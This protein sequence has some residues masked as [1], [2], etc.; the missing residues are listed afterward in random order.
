LER[1][2]SGEDQGQRPCVR[3]EEQEEQEEQEQVGRDVYLPRMSGVTSMK[4]KM[5]MKMKMMMMMKKKKKNNNNNN[6]NKNK[7]G[8]M[9]TFPDQVGS[10]R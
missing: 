6:K 4:M 2:G 3:K 5:K 8:V 7:L 10:P 1:S 9:F